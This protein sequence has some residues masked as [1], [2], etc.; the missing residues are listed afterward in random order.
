MQLAMA[1]PEG[2]FGGVK[3]CCHSYPSTDYMKTLAPHIGTVR[4]PVRLPFLRLWRGKPPHPLCLPCLWTN[5]RLTMEDTPNLRV[6]FLSFALSSV[7]AWIDISDFLPGRTVA[8][9]SHGRRRWHKHHPLPLT[10]FYFFFLSFQDGQ[11]MCSDVARA[12]FF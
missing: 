10:I 4:C 11:L 12:F 8:H 6:L 7:V 3:S 5:L 1:I 2:F 9:E